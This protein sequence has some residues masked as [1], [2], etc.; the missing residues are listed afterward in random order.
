[1]YINLFIYLL[2]IYILEYRDLLPIGVTSSCN[3]ATLLF[4]VGCFSYDILRPS[5]SDAEA[6]CPVVEWFNGVTNAGDTAEVCCRTLTEEIEGEECCS[7]WSIDM[8]ETP[9]VEFVKCTECVEC[10]GIS[11][12]PIT[13]GEFRP[14]VWFCSTDCGWLFCCKVTFGFELFVAFWKC[15][16]ERQGYIKLDT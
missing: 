3:C 8:T 13:I 16:K 2:Y 11:L 9:V 4:V 15:V 12:V 14:I 5:L 6:T 10:K 1:M 7:W